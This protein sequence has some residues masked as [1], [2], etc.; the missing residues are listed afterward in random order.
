MPIPQ[1]GGGQ[2]PV[3]QPGMFNAP[4]QPGMATPNASAANASDQFQIA[5]I[6][7]PEFQNLSA[8][9]PI[10]AGIQ[11]GNSRA[12]ANGKTPGSRMQFTYYE[13]AGSHPRQSLPCVI[14]ASAG[15][16]LMFGIAEPTPEYDLETRP[17]VEAGFAVLGISLDG[18][19]ADANNSK[20]EQLQQAFQ[21]FRD[22]GGGLVNVR[23]GI[24][25]LIRKVPQVDPS[26]QIGRAHV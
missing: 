18:K 9:R 2:A 26:R 4:N 24:E 14:V 3:A 10:T 21:E 19:L 23:N 15:T 5:S 20:L 22:S 16:N 13:P 8:L 1:Q 11:V 7:I 6:P 12:I 25:F 17:Y